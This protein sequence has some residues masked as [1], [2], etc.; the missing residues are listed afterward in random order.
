MENAQANVSELLRNNSHIKGLYGC[1]NT[2]TKGIAAVLMRAARKDIV[3]AGFDLAEET[4][5]LIR[6]PDYHGITLLQKQDQMAYKGMLSLDRQIRGEKVE[7]KYIDT[8]VLLVDRDYLLEN[9]QN[10]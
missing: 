10:E 8:G 9:E 1:N 7:Q 4:A 6:N 5:S 2:S 3:M